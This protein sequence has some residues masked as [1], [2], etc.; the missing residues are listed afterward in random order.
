M[1][2]HSSEEPLHNTT[3]KSKCM[4]KASS[5]RVFIETKFLNLY[6]SATYNT[7]SPC[8]HLIS[9]KPTRYAVILIL[10]Y[11]GVWQPLQLVPFLNTWWLQQLHLQDAWL[12]AWLGY[13]NL[14]SWWDE[15]NPILL[16]PSVWG[17]K[18]RSAALLLTAQICATWSICIFPGL[19]SSNLL[20]TRTWAPRQH[21]SLG[22]MLPALLSVI[23]GACCR[24]GN[25]QS[26]SEGL[27]V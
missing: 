19:D 3:V 18:T 1:L 7:Q 11:T 9:I 22:S 24:S 2:L 17:Y 5:R 14:S 8:L 12:A 20:L 4:I 25:S 26:S 27:W 16:P 13:F 6:S 21:L 10:H 15:D 23:F